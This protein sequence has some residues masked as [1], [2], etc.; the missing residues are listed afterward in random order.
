DLNADGKLDLVVMGVDNYYGLCYF[1][2]LLGH[3]DG[4]F[5]PDAMSYGPYSSFF[6]ALALGDFDG[7]GNADVAFAVDSSV[8]VFLSNGDGTL[9][10]PRE[11]G[12]GGVSVTVADLDADGKL[13]LATTDSV[14]RGN[15]DGTFQPA[16]SFTTEAQPG[17]VSAADVSGDG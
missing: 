3:G 16:Q 1:S 4:S 9:Q 6:P 14:L 10:E 15:G 17:L 2:V 5:G 12:T 11:F 8:K 7:G 13:D